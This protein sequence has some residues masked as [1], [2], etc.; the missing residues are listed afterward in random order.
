MPKPTNLKPVGNATRV[1]APLIPLAIAL[2]HGALTGPAPQP[3]PAA[4][5]VTQLSSPSATPA[6]PPCGAGAPDSPPCQA[7]YPMLTRGHPVAWWFVFKF[8]AAAF[9]GCGA[10]ATRSCLFGGTPQPYTN[11]GQ[12]YV[13]ASSEAPTLQ[14]GDGCAG[15]TTSDP[16]GATFDQVYNNGFHY[17]VWNDQFYDDPAIKGCTRQCGS[18]WGHSKGLVAWNDAGEGLVMQ[19]STPSWPAAGSSK[20][21]RKTDGNTLGCVKDNDVQVSQHFF[22]LRLTHDDLV[23]VLQGLSNS[24][25]VTDPGNTQIVSNGGPADVQ[26]LVTRLGVKSTSATYTATTL[27]SGV[28]LISKPSS[29]NVPPWQMVSAVLGGVPLRT[30]TWWASPQIYSTDAS[31]PVSC[32]SPSLPAPGPVQIATTGTWAGK[33]FALTG[34]LGTNFNHAKLGVSTSGAN[35]YA[36]FG[37]MNQQG[38][39]S[40]TN[41]ASSQNGRGGLFYAV[42]NPQLSDS[43]SALIT[44]A[45]APTQPAAK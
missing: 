19:V 16:I 8:N 4:V 41:C 33:T 43:L 28:Q 26:Q 6:I 39:L 7:P 42:I 3:A 10:S 27:S 45:T 18:P 1:V 11:F 2:V 37:D 25:V 24:S 21:P 40:G 23:K 5:P 22:A 12:Q 20:V 29:L 9:P 34:G 31:T 15:D 30:A 44:G 14:Q 36:I 32:W 13:Y 38:T 35:R 17:V